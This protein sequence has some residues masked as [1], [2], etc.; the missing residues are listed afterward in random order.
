[1]PFDDIKNAL[2]AMDEKTFSEAHL[3]QLLL[4]APD[5]K[6]VREKGAIFLLVF[7]ASVIRVA[8]QRLSPPTVIGVKRCVTTLIT[9]A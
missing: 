7:Y 5:S 1:M 9:A 4:Y 8:T 3:K 2:L 6:E